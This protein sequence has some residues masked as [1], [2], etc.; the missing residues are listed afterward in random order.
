MNDIEF[1]REELSKLPTA[2]R[3]DAIISRLSEVEG[4]QQAVNA[5]RTLTSMIEAANDN[6]VVC[7]NKVVTSIGERVRNHL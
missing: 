1:V 5:R 2:L 4:D 3:F 6:V 7:F